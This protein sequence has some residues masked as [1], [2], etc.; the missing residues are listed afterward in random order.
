M[1][2]PH[3]YVLERM[4]EIAVE[5]RAATRVLD[6]PA[7]R[8]VLTVPLR[9]A[10]FDVVGCDLFPEFLHQMLAGIRG[11]TVM[12]FF[13]EFKRGHLS[14]A[15]KK[16]LFN[17]C[18]P[19]TPNQIRCVAGDMEG[20]L[21]FREK[22]FNVI[23]CMEGI[24]HVTDRHK[25]LSEFHRILKPGGTLVLSTP[26]M[27]SLRA[28]TAYALAGQRT[29]KGHLDEYTSVWGR[30]KNGTRIYHGHAFLVNYFQVRYSLHHCGFRIRRLLPSNKSPTSMALFPFLVPFVALFTLLSQIS[31][32]KKFRQMVDR[33]E[34]PP[35]TTPPTVEVF[36]H[37]M[38]PRMLLTTV[39]I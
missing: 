27:L 2:G 34:I 39:K 18:D 28:R 6:V 9:M 15:L 25:V 23:L 1:S 38:S 16:R 13:L 32:R 10:G 14:P 31:A 4:A 35:G 8:G 20:R 12:E 24:E 36:R 22:S 33:G 30:S 26:N 21:P 3:T 7:G 19:S 11:R 5:R 17:G 29:F 37:V